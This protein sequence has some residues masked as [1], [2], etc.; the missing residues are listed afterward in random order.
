MWLQEMSDIKELQ[1]TQ[2]AQYSYIVHNVLETNVVNVIHAYMNTLLDIAM[3][4][5]KRIN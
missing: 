2:V 5:A 4:Q 1:N 3:E